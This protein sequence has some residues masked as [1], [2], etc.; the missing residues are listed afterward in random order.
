[1]YVCQLGFFAMRES[2]TRGSTNIVKKWLR[3]S[4]RLLAPSNTFCDATSVH[5]PCCNML[6][7]L[8]EHGQTWQ[9]EA[10]IWKIVS[11]FQIFV[12]DGFCSRNYSVITSAKCQLGKHVFGNSGIVGQSLTTTSRL[13][14]KHSNENSDFTPETF[15]PPSNL[16]LH[17]MH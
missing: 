12:V 17:D 4:D 9:S 13:D 2:T 5:E 16:P 6:I 14:N 15:A 3:R 7:L 8:H 11:Y 10:F 1:M